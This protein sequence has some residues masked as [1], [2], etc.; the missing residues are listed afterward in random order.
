MLLMTSTF[1]LSSRTSTV[2]TCVP[3]GGLAS[4]VTLIASSVSCPSAAAIVDLSVLSDTALDVPKV[5]VTL[6]CCTYTDPAAS[7]GGGKGEGGS[8]GGVGEG[9]R[10]GGGSTG[11]GGE[12]GGG[13]GP[14][15]STNDTTA[16]EV[17]VTD[18]PPSALLIL[19]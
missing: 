5:M 2:A 12:G 8:D 11:G 14:A 9:G 15:S 17:T 16:G 18:T 3:A 1:G 4:N 7:G 10:D 19:D 6:A 13:D